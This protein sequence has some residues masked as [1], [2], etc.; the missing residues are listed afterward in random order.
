MRLP[1]SPEIDI[2]IVPRRREKPPWTA[3]GLH[4]AFPKIRWREAVRVD[5]A[6]VDGVF[7]CRVCLAN[8]GLEE[9]EVAALLGGNDP[10]GRSL[11]LPVILSQ[12]DFDAHMA[13]EHPQPVDL[14]MPPP[15]AVPAAR[16]TM[17]PLVRPPGV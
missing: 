13:T 9:R 12:D 8:E 4:E 10:G 16:G 5:V 6:G 2:D 1:V 17:P 3:E 15:G 7:V 14:T 11:R